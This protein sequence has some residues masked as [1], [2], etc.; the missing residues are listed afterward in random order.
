[1]EDLLWEDHLWE[2]HI[3]EDHIWEDHLWKDQQWEV[4]LEV[5]G[6]MAP[7]TAPQ[8]TL[9]T[10]TEVAG[11]PP[12]PSSRQWPWRAEGRGPSSLRGPRDME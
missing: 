2:D 4:P 10:H 8:A 5:V 6:G 9:P 7:P 1:M 3:W 12:W 11:S